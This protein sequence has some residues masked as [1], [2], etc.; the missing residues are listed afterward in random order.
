M[1]SDQSNKMMTTALCHCVLDI[2]LIFSSLLPYRLRDITNAKVRLFF[3]GVV[4]MDVNS[5]K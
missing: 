1:P 2:I 5:V 4:F 3:A